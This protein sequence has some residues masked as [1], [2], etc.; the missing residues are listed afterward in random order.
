[1]IELL[2][3]IAVIAILIGLLLPA[4]Q[5]VRESAAATMC[6]N[7]IRQIALACLNYESER[8]TLPPG[9]SGCDSKQQQSYLPTSVGGTGQHDIGEYPWVATIAWEAPR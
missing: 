1:M 7:N 8:G 2:V 9:Y 6:K 3:V 4:V 5:K